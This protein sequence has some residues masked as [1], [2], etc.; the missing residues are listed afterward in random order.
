V[1]RR[2]HIETELDRCDLDYEIVKAIDGSTF[3]PHEMEKLAD[4]DA[5]RKSPDWLSPNMVACALSHKKVYRKIADD[6]SECAFVLEDDV[7]LR[8]DIRSILQAVEEHLDRSEV[9]LLHYMSFA[10]LELSTRNAAQLLD[11]GR[12]LYPMFLRGVVGASAYVI[13]RSAAEGMADTSALISTASDDW[14]GFYESGYLDRIRCVHPMPVRTI[15]AKSTISVA[16][17]SGL[18]SRVTEWIDKNK[19]PILSSCLTRYRL[20]N[21]AEMSNF[22]TSDDLSPLDPNYHAGG[23]YPTFEVAASNLK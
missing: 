6:G 18:R 5:V 21:I 12:L 14:L 10:P 22:T 13:T 3:T 4:I 7:T 17:Q 11:G 19:I 8:E 1:T 23:R 2:Q 20:R 16:S 15:G 9:A